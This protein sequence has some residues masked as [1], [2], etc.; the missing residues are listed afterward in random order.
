MPNCARKATQIIG[1]RRNPRGV[2]VVQPGAR[3]VN[4]GRRKHVGPGQC[5]LLR[6]GGLRTLLETAA[7]RHAPENAGN[8]LRVV[9]IAEAVEDLV[10]V[11]EVEV[12]SGI[13]GVAVFADRRRSCRMLEDSDPL[14]GAG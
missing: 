7:I 2:Q 8:E 6:Q 10:L 3:N 13:K 4:H 5:A 12:Q 9:H 11:A 14:I 1:R